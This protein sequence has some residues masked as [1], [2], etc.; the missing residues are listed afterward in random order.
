[1]IVVT[2]NRGAPNALRPGPAAVRAFHQEKK[3]T[4]VRLLLARKATR[5][6]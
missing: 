2:G 5:D 6:A 1:M 4:H 3:R